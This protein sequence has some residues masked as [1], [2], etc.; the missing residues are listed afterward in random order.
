MKKMAGIMVLSL[1]LMLVFTVGASAMGWWFLGDNGDAPE[2]DEE[3]RAQLRELEQ[4]RYEQLTPLQ[5]EKR[6]IIFELRQEYLADEP[7]ESRIEELEN[8]LGELR[9]EMQTVRENYR[10]Q[11]GD[12]GWHCAGPRGPG[13]GHRWGGSRWNSNGQ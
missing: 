11:A 9:Q 13:G 6:D 4:E 10:S 5:E 7:D 1:V 12:Y 8:R 2:L 3:E